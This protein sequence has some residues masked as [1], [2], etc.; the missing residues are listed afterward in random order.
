VTAVGAERDRV[1]AALPE[2]P[3]PLGATIGEGGTNFAVASGA[4][5]GIVLC[6]FEE[7]GAET[8]LLLRDY[9][10]GV[11]HDFVPGRPGPRLRIPGGR[12]LRPGSRRAL[13]PCQAPSRSYARAFSGAVRYGNEVLGYAAAG[14]EVRWLPMQA[15]SSGQEAGLAASG[16]VRQ[17]ARAG[18]TA[19]R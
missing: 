18:S 4:A 10:A 19:S 16:L 15:T 1:V 2:I 3:F 8:Q 13:Q 6:L 17:D 11:W 7:A 5:D 9:D 14:A 12:A